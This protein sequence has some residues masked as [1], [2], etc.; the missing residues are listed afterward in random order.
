MMGKEEG[1]QENRA[2]AIELLKKME[3]V[4]PHAERW[5]LGDQCDEA[6]T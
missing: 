5:L 1:R 4:I 6:K 3:S 2:E